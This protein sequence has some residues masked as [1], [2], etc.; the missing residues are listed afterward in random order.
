M[1]QEKKILTARRK[2]LMGGAAV[3]LSSCTQQK[4]QKQPNQPKMTHSIGMTL[5]KLEGA[6]HGGE[7]VL[8]KLDYPYNALEPYYDEQTLKIHHTKHHQGYVNG[9]NKTIDS[10]KAARRKGDYGNIKALERNLAFHGSGH[11]LHCLFWKSMKPG[12]SDMPPLLNN[13]LTESFGSV[14]AAKEHLAMATKKV[15]ASGWGIM[16]YEPLSSSIIILQAEKHQ[17]L[18][19]TGTIPLLVCDVWEHAYYLKYKNDRAAW[20]DN[21]MKLANWSFASKRLEYAANL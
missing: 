7:Y 12:G 15:E 14:E 13:A 16:A 2:F 1:E 21:F 11:V 19:M 6:Y 4:Q 9:L 8:P 10:L 17:N 5:S 20:V 3:L 18:T